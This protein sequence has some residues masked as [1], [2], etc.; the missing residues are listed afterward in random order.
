M[1]VLILTTLCAFS[2][3]FSTALALLLTPATA[4]ETE[5]RPGEDLAP[6]PEAEEVSSMYNSGFGAKRKKK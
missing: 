4:C 5:L 2:A 6:P 3:L 1:P